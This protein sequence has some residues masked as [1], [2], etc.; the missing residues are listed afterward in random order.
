MVLH[1]AACL[2][3]EQVENAIAKVPSAAE[4]FDDGRLPSSTLFVQQP[5]PC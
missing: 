5:W 3:A 4:F 2:G 1:F